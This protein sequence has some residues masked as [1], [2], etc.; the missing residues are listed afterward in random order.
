MKKTTGFLLAVLFCTLFCTL[1][2]SCAVNAD[3]ELPQRKTYKNFIYHLYE[4]GEIGIVG[5][6]GSGKTVSIPE[7]IGGKPVV[8]VEP[9]AFSDCT[10][11][12]TV[13][14]PGSVKTIGDFAFYGCTSLSEIKLSN[15]VTTIGRGAFCDCVALTAIRLPNSVRQIM[16]GAF[17]NCETLAE[18]DFPSTLS[19]VGFYVLFGTDY[20]NNEKNWEDGGLYVGNC[21]LSVSADSTECIVK[22][23]TE[24]IADEAFSECRE[25]TYAVLPAGIK[26]IGRNPF[27][28]CNRLSSLLLLDSSEHV[29]QAGG[30]GVL[31]ED[32]S[33][34][35]TDDAQ[36][37]LWL[38]KTK[39]ILSGEVVNSDATP[40]I[41]NDRT[42]LPV[43]LVAEGLDAEVL[44]NAAEPNLV[45]VKKDG[46]ELVI[47]VGAEYATVNQT[48][49]LLDS[50]AFLEADR[51]FLPLRFIAEQL[52]AT[53]EWEEATGRITITD[54]RQ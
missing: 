21:L 9:Q 22:Q 28:G 13:T 26:T 46:T 49:V 35:R 36:M 37:V 41:V 23:G 31:P 20:E 4:N 54:V 50:P 47:T 3:A 1:V 34:C 7:A 44:W 17:L 51:I 32:V 52:G 8:S 16:D 14:V 27:A 11:L 24:L 29:E 40:K 38:D 33:I 15:G 5:W 12:E 6:N 30:L 45:R 19:S 53:A 25:L 48:P 10:A 43:R 2:L 39:M 42:M 18:V